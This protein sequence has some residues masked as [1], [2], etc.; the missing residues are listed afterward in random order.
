M[1]ALTDPERSAAVEELEASS[2]RLLAALEG[3][4]EEQWRSR[5]TPDRWSIAECAEHIT[6]AEIAL[7]KL[8]EKALTEDLPP[9]EERT[10]I[11]EKDDFVRTFLRDRSRRDEAPER[12]QPKGRFPTREETIRTF[13]ERRGANLSYVRETSQPLRDRVAPHPFAGV[14]D[15][16]QW[17]LFLAAH[18]DRHAAQIEETR[19]ALKVEG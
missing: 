15:G 12:L 11:R 4:S 8:F 17:I 16:Y 14:I 9:G 18:T 10:R 19:K 2:R 6:A 7:P 1:T 5:P 13:E 3:L